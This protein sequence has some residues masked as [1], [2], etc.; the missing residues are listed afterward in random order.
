M[1]GVPGGDGRS[2]R[3]VATR[4]RLLFQ[5]QRRTQSTATSTS[6]RAGAG[7]CSTAAGGARRERVDA[8]AH[9]RRGR[10]SAGSAGAASQHHPVVATG[11]KVVRRECRGS[12]RGRGCRSERVEQNALVAVQRTSPVQ[13]GAAAGRRRGIGATR[14][15]APNPLF[16]VLSDGTG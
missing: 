8:R 7:A 5:M 13:R 10:A 12:A 6:R 1:L 4:R 11:L 16:T 2:E 3:E 14:V 15:A 9:C